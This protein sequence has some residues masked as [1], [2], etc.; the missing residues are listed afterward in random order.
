VWDSVATLALGRWVVGLEEEGMRRFYSSTPPPQERSVVSPGGMDRGG[1]SDESR[2]VS[3]DSPSS[4]AST[5]GIRD[6]ATSEEYEYEIPE[7]V[8]V[9]KAKMRFDLL[10]RRAN[11]DCMQMDF[12]RRKF[13][14]KS[15]VYTW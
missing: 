8:R 6:R 4:P 15:I 14:V 3:L 7:E 1:R 12:D 9:R 5:A 11:M 10:E 2:S 13:V